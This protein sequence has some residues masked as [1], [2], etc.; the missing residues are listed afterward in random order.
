MHLKLSH[1]WLNIQVS[2]FAH[3]EKCN[4]NF[5][6]LVV[7]P[8]ICVNLLHSYKTQL[9]FALIEKVSLNFSNSSFVI[10]VNLLHPCSFM[11]YHY[12]FGVFLS[13]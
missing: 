11:V 1:S 3:L 2:Q 13:K 8:V 6:K 4:L 5:L 10:R 12:V 7:C 9:R